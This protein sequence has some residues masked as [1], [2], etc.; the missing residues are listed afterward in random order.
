MK[1]ATYFIEDEYLSQYNGMTFD[2][3]A[4]KVT[5]DD[6]IWIYD[7]I[8]KEHLDE[9]SRTIPDSLVDFFE[10][11]ISDL[12]DLVGDKEVKINQLNKYQKKMLWFFGVTSD[13]YWGKSS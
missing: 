11:F 10:P 12:Y 1:P 3:V 5:S 8:N 6:I 7:S 2:E 13:F 9:K 4:S